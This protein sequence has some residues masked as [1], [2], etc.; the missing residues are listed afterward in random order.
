M[1]KVLLTACIFMLISI[2]SH[3]QE[4]SPPQVD[5]SKPT[6][7]YT[8]VNG[9]LEYQD[10]KAG[11]DLYG[12]RFN[13]TYAFD[14]N[15]LILAEIPFLYNSETDKFGPSDSRLRYF[16]VA[17]RNLS[18]RIIAIAPYGDIT[19]PTGCYQRRLGN[20]VW[21]FSAGVVVGIG[22]SEKI[23]MFPGAGYI[24]VTAPQQYEG[25]SQS[26]FNVQT[27]MSI[28]F[29]KRTFM[30]VNPILTVLN[31]TS[32]S[33]EF[34]LNYMVKPNKLKVNAGYFPDFTNESHTIR[35]GATAFL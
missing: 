30:F 12:T 34:N 7:L 21:S 26:G 15:N 35:I 19:L 5:P 10:R 4:D 8:Q 9:M 13:I 14:A 23:A 18:K 31:S 20:N 29:S 1:N 27:N 33:G 25:K 22:I 3:A 2:G 17:K 24:F 16:H 28:S 32:W 11:G 6:N